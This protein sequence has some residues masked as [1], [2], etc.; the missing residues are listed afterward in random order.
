MARKFVLVPQD[1]YHS[2]LGGPENSVAHAREEL[3]STLHDPT[4]TVAER[5][6]LYNK[7]LYD[8]RRIRREA[9]ERPVKV[10]VTN[11]PPLPS[12]LQENSSNVQAKTPSGQVRPLDTPRVPRRAYRRKNRTPATS[13]TPNDVNQ[14]LG[15]IANNIAR[16]GVDE[17]GRIKNLN[18]RLVPNSDVRESVLHLLHPKP[19]APDPPGAH[20]LR[21][22]LATSADTRKFI[23]PDG[24]EA[25]PF[26]QEGQGASKRFKPT[27]WKF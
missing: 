2:L 14:L 26:V 24:A 15:L 7:R 10:E 17:K 19:F 3:E 27:L 18:G 6:L 1:M 13:S 22:R 5:N 25:E 4:K 12:E 11:P 20:E 23:F 16:Y 9:E 8:F 21:T